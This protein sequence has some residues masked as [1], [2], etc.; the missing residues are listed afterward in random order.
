MSHAE[1]TTLKERIAREHPLLTVTGP[2]RKSVAGV[3]CY[4]LQVQDPETLRRTVVL[5]MDDYKYRFWLFLED[6]E[7]DHR[8]A[9]P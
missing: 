8:T 7:D 4:D 5:D 2:W 3:I 6:I 9:N 1:A